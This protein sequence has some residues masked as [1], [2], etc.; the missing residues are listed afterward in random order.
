MNTDLIQKSKAYAES[1]LSAL[2]DDYVYHNLNH[3]KKVAAAAE[4]IGEKSGLSFPPGFMIP[5]TSMVPKITKINLLKM[6][7]SSYQAGMHRQ[8]K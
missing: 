5:A 4:E 6:P 3:T 1:K 8:K 7:N 2:K